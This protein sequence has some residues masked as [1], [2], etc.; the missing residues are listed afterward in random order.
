MTKAIIASLCL[1]AVPFGAQAATTTV[2]QLQRTNYK[3]EKL[4]VYDLS[5]DAS[6]CAISRKAPW[7]VYYRDNS[8]G[9]RLEQFSSDSARYFGPKSSLRAAADEISLSFLALEEFQKQLGERVSIT[10]SV[11][12][13]DGKCV[14]TSEISYR[15]QRFTLEKIFIKMK[16][17]FGFPSGVESLI[18]TG[19]ADDGSAVRDCVAGNC[20]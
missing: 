20:N 15:N 6:T 2:L 4:L 19:K 18:V 17:T 14:V 12:K 11:D 16:K 8:T 13:I 3:P 7:D 5:Y 9:Q 1:I 10:A